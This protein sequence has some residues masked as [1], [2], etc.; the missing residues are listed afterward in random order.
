MAG[1]YNT[2]KYL[3]WLILKDCQKEKVLVEKR[4][5]GEDENCIYSVWW[6]KKI[7]A[8]SNTERVPRA[9]RSQDRV[10]YLSVP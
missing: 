6:M 5:S 9:S 2:K 1:P 10:T 4:D 8:F 3:L 7:L